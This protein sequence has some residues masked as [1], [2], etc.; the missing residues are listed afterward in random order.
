MVWGRLASD[1]NSKIHI[2]LAWGKSGEKIE[3]PL[4]VDQSEKTLL[5]GCVTLSKLFQLPE[6][7][8]S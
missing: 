8:S 2:F 4:E 3:M 7:V 1:E 5:S 6:C